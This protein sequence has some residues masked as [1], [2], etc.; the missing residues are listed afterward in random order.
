MTP[1]LR[2][3]VVSFVLALGLF[4]AACDDDEDLVTAPPAALQPTATA[5]PSPAPTATPTPA[6]NATPN[7]GDVVVFLGRIRSIDNFRVEIGPYLV[8]TSLSTSY[9]RNG[10]PATLADFSVG[11]D[12]RV[13]GGV[14]GD[15][16]IS[17]D[18]I[19]LLP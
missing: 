4:A 6:P 5:S 19:A 13:K 9:V 16:S 14:L 18:R 7:E 1:L 11:E 12:V 17:A 10:Q 3:I 2:R 15:G 8:L